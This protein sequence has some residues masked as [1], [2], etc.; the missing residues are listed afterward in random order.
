MNKI[1]N[2]LQFSVFF[3]GIF[4][5][6]SAFA[7]AG[8]PDANDAQ[9]IQKIEE[10]VSLM[11]ADE[12]LGIIFAGKARWPE[13]KSE[14]VAGD[15]E[16]FQ[17]LC[18]LQFHHLAWFQATATPEQKLMKINS[19]C[20]EDVPNLMPAYFDGLEQDEVIAF[21]KKPGFVANLRYNQ[22]RPNFMKHIIA[23]KKDKKL[24]SSLDY[25]K[26]VMLAFKGYQLNSN[27]ADFQKFDREFSFVSA[28]PKPPSGKQAP[29]V[30]HNPSDLK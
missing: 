2:F 16:Q 26:C 3:A 9:V 4:F 21:L 1:I 11:T 19:Y 20:K 5:G 24:E 14:S 23:I 29:V 6:N 8:Q 18:C 30:Q 7:A 15:R 12:R 13:L 28:R 22:M 27:D 17:Y 10:E 25:Q